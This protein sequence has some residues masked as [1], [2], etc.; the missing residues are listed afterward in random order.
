M[1]IYSIFTSWLIT[2]V[3]VLTAYHLWRRKKTDDRYLAYFWFL[4]AIIWL[5]GGSRALLDE[6]GIDQLSEIIP[7]FIQILV[8]IHIMPFVTLIILRL[9]KNATIA[10]CA[11][12]AVLILGGL[13]VFYLIKDGL[14]PTVKTSYGPD[15]PIPET[16]TLIFRM[17]FLLGLPALILT[18]SIH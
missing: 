9:T 10:K 7:Y 16:A 4:V 8:P 13:F 17:I 11:S 6:L 5:L 1:V 2:L 12:L 3:G 14:L 15:T 18:S